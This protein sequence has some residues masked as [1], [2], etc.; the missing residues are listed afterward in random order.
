MLRNGEMGK[1]KQIKLSAVSDKAVFFAKLG[2]SPMQDCDD[3]SD[4]EGE[5]LCYFSKA[6]AQLAWD[7]YQD[8]HLCEIDRLQSIDRLKL[9]AELSSLVKQDSIP[10]LDRAKLM[11]VFNLLMD[12]LGALHKVDIEPY[13][14]NRADGST[15]GASLQDELPLKIGDLAEV[16]ELSAAYDRIHSACAEQVSKDMVFESG[17][18]VRSGE[19]EF[20]DVKFADVAGIDEAKLEL[21]E[22]VDFLKHPEKFQKMGARIPRGV[23]LEGGPGVGK[24]LLAKAVAGE[25][26]VPFLS[27]SGPDFVEKYVGVGASR[28][29]ELFDQARAQGTCIIFI[30]EIDAVGRARSE[31]PSGGAQEHDSTLNAML[32]E[33]DGFGRDS[34]IIVIAATNR[35]DLLDAALTRP[36]RFDRKVE[37]PLPA[38]AGREAILKVHAKKVPLDPSVDL[39]VIARL[40]GGYSGA[41]LAN[42]VNEATL[43]AIR[44]DHD[45]VTAGDFEQARDRAIMSAY[46]PGYQLTVKDKAMTAY[47]EAGHALVAHHMDGGNEVFKVTIAPR[48]NSLGSTH[49]MPEPENGSI[50][51]K[52]LFA[53]L[54]S[55][56]GGRLAES[57][58][59][60]DDEVTTGASSDL[61]RASQLARKMVAE[62]GF[63]DKIG[64]SNLQYQGRQMSISGKS[65]EL[66]DDEVRVLL[67]KA[68]DAAKAIIIEH[69]D[70]M[71]AMATMLLEKETIDA[72]DM[73]QIVT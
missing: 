49:Y 33:M 43:I 58:F 45:L 68:N 36:G 52:Q 69:R 64:P 65:A 73:R 41:E 54:A 67:G 12:K 56:L 21:T 42:L 35:A 66:I 62:W 25:A 18:N 44:N 55:L 48:G 17:L 29:R 38:I 31:D 40:T 50:N 14:K 1:L 23:L 61:Y 26:G 37:V 5:Q 47:H 10:S 11:Y 27:V 3:I 71:D 72:A 13:L 57:V 19:L 39:K 20:S 63:S 9:G 2:V 15:D 8:F 70:Q 51:R 4:D 16:I 28:V 24:T 46:M 59:F 22:V 34:N 30:D 53:R 60:G 7:D 6:T 32:V